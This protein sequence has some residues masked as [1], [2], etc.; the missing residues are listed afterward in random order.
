MDAY[1]VE[2][3]LHDRA[4]LAF[5]AARIAG[6]PGKFLTFQTKG[7]LATLATTPGLDFRTCIRGV[8]TATVDGL[9]E[10]LQIWDELAAP[11][12]PLTTPHPDPAVDERLRSLGFVPA[13]Q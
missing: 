9:T 10:V 12:P 13:G 5:T 2:Q 8:T 1:L 7:L 6:L 11:M 4:A 3:C